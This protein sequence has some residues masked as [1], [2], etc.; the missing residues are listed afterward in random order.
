[1]SN[2]LW[3]PNVRH[4]GAPIYRAIADALERD[5][6]SGML[7]DGARLPTHR[8]LAQKLGVTPLTITRAYKEASRRGL[9]DSSVGRSTF[10]RT[11]AAPLFGAVTHRDTATVDLAKNIIQ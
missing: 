4:E 5:I 3:S 10:V 9:I 6:D 2:T 7:R 11:P 1:M 8:Q